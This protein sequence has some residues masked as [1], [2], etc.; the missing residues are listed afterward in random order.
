MPLLMLRLKKGLPTALAAFFFAAVSINVL[1][2]VVPIAMIFGFLCSCALYHQ[3]IYHFAIR[4]KLVVLYVFIVLL[5]A[6]WSVTPSSTVWYGIQLFITIGAAILIGISA[7]PRQLVRGIFAAMAFIILASVISGRQGPS[8]AGMVLVGVTGGKT[9]IGLSAVA[10]VG[11]GIAILFDRQQ[12]LLYRLATLPSIPIGAY[13]AAHV[14]AATALV[15]LVVFPIAFFGF[16]GLRYLNVVGRWVLIGALLVIA[17]PSSLAVYAYSDKL[18]QKILRV[19]NKDAT[20]SGRTIMWA[21]A[22]SWM[23]QSPLL[24]HGFRAFWTSGSSDSLGILHFF[25]LTD[26]RAFQLHSTIKEV[27]VDTGWVGLLGFSIAAAI[28]VYHVIAFVFL[29]PTPSSAFIAAMF[30]M[31]LAHVPIE[32]IV[33]VFFPPTLFF[34]ACGTTAIVFFMNRGLSAEC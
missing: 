1:P 16:L 27:R 5:S 15:G 31:M 21:K 9:A 34:Y 12:P 20:L 19:L 28:F 29:Y 32:T 25:S 6:T 17:V 7:S 8:A 26:P 24:G 22:D 14:Q 2:A 30:L 13:L 18:D 10:L 11:S 33:G 3:E 23:Q 4:N